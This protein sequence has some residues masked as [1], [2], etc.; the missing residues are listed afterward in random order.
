VYAWLGARLEIETKKINK[1]LDAQG[2]KP[3][4]NGIFL[5]VS[6]SSFLD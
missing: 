3:Q 1:T 4:Y 5:E 6:I 2:V